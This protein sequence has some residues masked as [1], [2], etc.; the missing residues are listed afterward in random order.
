METG[1]HKELLLLG[2]FP[3]NPEARQALTP[4]AHANSRKEPL[5][6]LP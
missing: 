6:P 1:D 3:K 5:L 2:S 4:A